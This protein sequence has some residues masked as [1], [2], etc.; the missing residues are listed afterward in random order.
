M[1]T[2]VSFCSY[3]KVKKTRTTEALSSVKSLT[4]DPPLSHKNTGMYLET[5]RRTSLSNSCIDIEL[6]CFLKGTKLIKK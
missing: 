1:L 3:K 6:L 5:I 2:K 4:F